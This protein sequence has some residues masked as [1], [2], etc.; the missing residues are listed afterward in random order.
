MA[1]VQ[2]IYPLHFGNYKVRF[3]QSQVEDLTDETKQEMEIIQVHKRA[4]RNAHENKLQILEKY[5]FP[6]MNTKINNIV[7][8]CQTCKEQKYDRHPNNPEIKATP[9]PQYPGHILHIDIYSTERNLV[10]TA[11]DK[12]SKYVQARTI[13]SKAIED[14][15]QPL[16]DLVFIFGVPKIIVIDNEKSLNSSTI[17][18]M[19]KD[20]LGIQI[21]K[22]PPYK[23]TVNGQ[24]ERFHS[25]LSEIMRCL[26]TERTYNTFK[27]LLDRAIY[28]YNF[29]IHSTTGKKPI[30][31]FFGRNVSTDPDQFEKS[32]QDN[33]SRLKEKQALDL[34]NHNKK[35][36][37]IKN[38][39]TGEVIY[40]KVNK[41][42]G[43][44]MSTKYRKEIVKTNNSTT[45]LTESG[46]IVHKSNI[47]S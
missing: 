15:K 47:K 37:P 30:E 43:S 31:V 28:E 29:S 14:I 24:I 6:R 19:I 17:N 16:H 3:T 45:V 32:R 8:Q 18:F 38:Y 34:L 39:N 33:I 27:E 46:K 40:I 25:T 21:I 12:F 11:I 5:Y 26:K 10:L 9:I 4:H 22:T 13:K 44:K 20:Q 41:R 42:L 23:S 36:K 35:R 2:D 7:K 1:K